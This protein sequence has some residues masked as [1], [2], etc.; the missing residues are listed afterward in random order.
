M[1]LATA[2]DSIENLRTVK[3]THTAAVA[4]NEIIMVSGVVLIAVNAA[5]ANA[6]NAYIYSG[7]VEMPKNN[8]L[9]I[10]EFDQLY[11]DAAD[12]ELNKSPAG[13]TLLGFCLEPALSAATTVVI[14]LQ[15]KLDVISAGGVT[16]THILIAAGSFTTAGGDTAETITIAGALATDICH[17]TV[18]T[19]GSTPSLVVEARAAAGQIDVVMSVD[20]STDHVLDYSLMR[21]VT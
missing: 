11:W 13:N 15:P 8:S 10:S 16:Q 18:N 12:S 1:A 17:V 19:K 6:A 20:P 9:V 2:R 14:M 4:V 3:Y 5:L 7:K 21:A